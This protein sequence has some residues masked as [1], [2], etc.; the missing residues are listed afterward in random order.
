MITEIG[1]QEGVFVDESVS[2]DCMCLCTCMCPC[3]CICCGLGFATILGPLRDSVGTTL[4]AVGGVAIWG[5][6]SLVS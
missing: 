1:S 5:A 6:V 4:S 2:S 3:I